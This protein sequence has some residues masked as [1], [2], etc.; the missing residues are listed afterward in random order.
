MESFKFLKRIA[1]FMRPSHIGT[2][3]TLFLFELD[4]LETRALGFVYYVFLALA[5]VIRTLGH[6]VRDKLGELGTIISAA[7]DFVLF[8]DLA[9]FVASTGA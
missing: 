1:H 7:G 8:T 3:R 9:V 4:R 5:A 6:A 2:R